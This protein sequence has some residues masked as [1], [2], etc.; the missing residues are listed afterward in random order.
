VKPA[1]GKTIRGTKT[2]TCEKTIWEGSGFLQDPIYLSI[3][4]KHFLGLSTNR[5][6]IINADIFWI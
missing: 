3:F 4:Q 6:T 1:L 2:K 5:Y